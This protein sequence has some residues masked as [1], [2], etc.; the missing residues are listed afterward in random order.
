MTSSHTRHRFAAQTLDCF[1]RCC[2][3][4]LQAFCVVSSASLSLCPTVRPIEN[5]HCCGYGFAEVE[6]Q[7]DEPGF[8]FEVQEG[9]HASHVNS[10]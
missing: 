8:C 6:R 3:L 10:G 2:M 4:E 5:D 7:A 1:R 9:H